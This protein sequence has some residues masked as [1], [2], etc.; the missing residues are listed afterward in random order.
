M[1]LLSSGVMLALLPA[2]AAATKATVFACVAYQVDPGKP[3]DVSFTAGSGY[4]KCML[5]SGTS[6]SATVSSKGLTCASLG[7]VESD[8]S[9]WCYWLSSY[10]TASYSANGITGTMRSQWYNEFDDSDVTLKDSSP[11]TSVCMNKTPCGST[12]QWWDHKKD[13]KPD[14]YIVFEPGSGFQ[15][16]DL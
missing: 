14:I 9:G 4:D 2:W 8:S 6:A 10:W 7:E 11:Y 5:K 1:Q 15:H 12:K 16:V 13:Q 3:F